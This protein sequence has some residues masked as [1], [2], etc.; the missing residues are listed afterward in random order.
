LKE[1]KNKHGHCNVEFEKA[2]YSSLYSW[3][4]I[5]RSDKRQ[6]GLQAER[7]AMLNEQGVSWNAGVLDAKWRERY[8]RLKQYHA[9]HGNSDVPDRYEGDSQLAKWVSKQ[10][11]QRKKNALS[12]EQV[13]LLDE[14]GFTWK[15]RDRGSWDDRLAEV[16]AF[17][18]KQGHCDIPM[19]ITDPPKLAAFINNTRSQRNSGTLSAGRIAK[20]DA[21]G[22]VWDKSTKI[23]EDG[24]N[25]AWKVRFD[26]L[27]QY[28]KMH[29]NCDV[30][31]C[32]KE[33]PQL[34][35]WVNQ[36]R[37]LKRNGNLHLERVRL[38]DEAGFV[39]GGKGKKIGV[40]GVSEDWKERF[41]ELLQ[42]KN[43]H[44]NC[45]VPT[46]WAENPRLGKWVVL[47]RTVKKS[48]KL[49]SVRE[50]LLDEAG[51]V[52]SGNKR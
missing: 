15:H 7:E 41:D 28:N 2:N 31:T 1:F 17:K 44:G 18:E 13:G 46:V 4:N 9:E 39:W 6:G 42:Y 25:D 45:A 26:E 5:Q 14:I 11:E 52:W 12:D 29:G 47:Q 32:S 21:V 30:P 38:L 48:G 49:D 43:E 8:E 40:G 27:V 36:Q 51:F 22:F 50:R 10:R 37:T 3:L 35:N 23:G 34:G 24:M 33:N 16:I 20:L 19:T